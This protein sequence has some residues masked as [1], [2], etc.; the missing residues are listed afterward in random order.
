[1]KR[2]PLVP[3]PDWPQKMEAVGFGFHSIDGIY[4]DE[5]ACY[6]L[7]AGEVDMLEAVT[8]ELHQMCIE[9]AQHVIDCDL[10]DRF[11]I[12]RE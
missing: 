6:A 12:P 9:A 5:R 1:M 4:W 7:T 10:F 11:A 3:R 2:E 8:N